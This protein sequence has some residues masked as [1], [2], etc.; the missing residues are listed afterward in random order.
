VFSSK[1]EQ[2]LF[3]K[4]YEWSFVVNPNRI[5]FQQ[6]Y[7]QLHYMVLELQDNIFRQIRGEEL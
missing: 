4:M 3:N 6:I 7:P 5:G 2:I 1:L